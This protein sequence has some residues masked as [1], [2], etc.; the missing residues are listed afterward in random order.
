MGLADGK[1]TK[2]VKDDLLHFQKQVR[3]VLD[4]LQ[5]KVMVYGTS[6]AEMSSGIIPKIDGSLRVDAGTKT[7][8]AAQALNTRLSQVGEGVEER[9]LWFERVLTSIDDELSTTIK[10][11]A[12]NESLNDASA[13][14]FLNGFPNTVD[15]LGNGGGSPRPGTDSEARDSV[16]DADRDT[17]GSGSSDDADEPGGNG[18]GDDA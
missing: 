10:G 1:V 14:E 9:L 18:G 13:K 8:P 2:V 17:D 11:F 16:R 12:D 15:A 7:F 6:D 5:T 4:D 3:A